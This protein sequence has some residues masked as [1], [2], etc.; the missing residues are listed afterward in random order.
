M[1]GYLLMIVATSF[2]AFFSKYISNSFPLI[3][4]TVVSGIISY[5]FISNLAGNEQWSGYFKPL[6]PS[7]LLVLVSLINLIPQ[8]IVY[9]IAGRYKKIVKG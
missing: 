6:K 1:F 8:V 9:K 3:I 2:L 7:Q 5:Y 4:G